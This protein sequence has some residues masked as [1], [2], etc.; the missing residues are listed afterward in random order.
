M[1]AYPVTPVFTLHHVS[2]SMCTHVETLYPVCCSWFM[3]KHSRP[4]PEE[5]V[6]FMPYEDSK[7]DVYRGTTVLPYLEVF[8]QYGAGEGNAPLIDK[9]NVHTSSLD[10]RRIPQHQKNVLMCTS[11]IYTDSCV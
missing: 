5:I 9:G 2:A 4:L 6:H 10:K 7:D 8:Y 1:S 11:T 3:F